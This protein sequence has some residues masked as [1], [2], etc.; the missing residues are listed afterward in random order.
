MRHFEV[1][2]ADGPHTDERSSGSGELHLVA[3]STTEKIVLAPAGRDGTTNGV[4]V[5]DDS[6]AHPFGDVDFPTALIEVDFAVPHDVVNNRDWISAHREPEQLESTG[7]QQLG[8]DLVV[9][10]GEARR[11]EHAA[12]TLCSPALAVEA[13]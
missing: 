2:R 7:G 4:G 5:D 12:P 9:K 3:R 11:T 6:G 10:G 13:L 1:R 8:H